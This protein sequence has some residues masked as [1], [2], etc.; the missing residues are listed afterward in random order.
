MHAA[1]HPVQ[2]VCILIVFGDVWSGASGASGAKSIHHHQRLGHSLA[3]SLVQSQVALSRGYRGCTRVRALPSAV[4]GT[5]ILPD[6]AGQAAEASAAAAELEENRQRM[7]ALKESLMSGAGGKA[8]PQSGGPAIEFK[9]PEFNM[10]SVSVPNVDVKVNLPE[11]NVKMPEV[12][13]KLPEV[14]IPLPDLS[15]SI[16]GATSSIEALKGSAGALVDQEIAALVDGIRAAGDSV[17]SQ[18]PP[19]VREQA[20]RVGDLLGESVEAYNRNPEGYSIV[21]GVALGVPLVLAYGAVY[22]GYNGVVKPAKAME[23]LQGGDVVLVD[24]RR[25]EDRAQDGV[26]LLKLAARGKGVALP[27]PELPTSVSRQVSDPRGL[28]TEILG[29]QIRSISKLNP[30]TKVI[31]MDRK[32]ELAKD[33]AR[34]CRAAGVR[35]AYVMGGGFNAYRL[36]DGLPVDGKSFYEDGPLAIAG[37]QVETLASGLRGAVGDRT[38]A[39]VALAGVAGVAFVGANLHEVLKYVG[40]LGIE[41]TVVLRYILGDESIGDDVTSLIN[42]VSETVGGDRSGDRSG[43]RASAASEDR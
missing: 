15:K 22:G 38:S 24:V 1:H 32:G 33:V 26:P 35:S 3:R 5:E 28:A 21:L 29:Q 17:L 43:D 7:A 12:N 4:P 39:A 8:A 30:D 41:A 20:I 14:D 40:V 19:G 36:Q 42:L 11:V 13:V 9:M 37:D 6:A 2:K 16:E 18:V 27:F 34:A 23:M 31:V 10:P 25:A